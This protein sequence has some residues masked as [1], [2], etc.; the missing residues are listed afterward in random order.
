MKKVEVVKK[1]EEYIEQNKLLFKGAT[2]LM[3]LS[4][5]KDSCFL[6]MLMLDLKEKY[7]LNLYAFHLNHLTRGKNSDDDEKHVKELC[8]N[9]NIKLYSESY[10]FSLENGNFEENARNIRYDFLYKYADISGSDLVATAHSL[11]DNV[12][13]ALYRLFRGT[14]LWG[15]CSIPPKR[16]IIIRPMLS[17]SSSEIITFLQANDC[18]WREDE[19]N[20]DNTYNRNFIRNNI[21][22][23]IGKR[24]DISNSVSNYINYS[25]GLYKALNDL[26]HGLIDIEEDK[27]EIVIYINDYLKNPD[28]LLHLLSDIIRKK[29]NQSISVNMMDEIFKNYKNLE[30]THTEI[31]SNSLFRIVTAIK[32]DRDVIILKELSNVKKRN[33]D[34]KY[35]KNIEIIEKNTDLHGV[36]VYECDYDYFKKHID[37]SKYIFIAP[38]NF[39]ILKI[40]NKRD[41]DYIQLSGGGKKIKKI[42]IDMKF[43]PEQKNSV[44]VICIDNNIAA[45]ASGYVSNNFNQIA[46]NFEVDNNSKKILAIYCNEKLM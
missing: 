2:V 12:E 42:M 15:M 30:K 6:L 45:F 8:M 43:S 27:E 16:N 5:G 40:R 4:A 19:S 35:N 31:Y 14:A 3:S 29:F 44:P 36:I 17:L 41:G 7:D 20:Q 39:K 28:I 23:E 37:S 34:V 21:I 1:A 26:I 32:N 22:P 38:G 46:G 9:N 18:K 33:F 13:T 25:C 10:D 11:S 24:F